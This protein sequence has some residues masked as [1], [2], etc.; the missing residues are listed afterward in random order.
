MSERTTIA[1]TES[2]WNP[3]RASA[4]PERMR[5]AYGQPTEEFED[6]KLGWSCVRVSPGCRNCYAAT[7]NRRLGTGLD[8][9]VSDNARVKHYL[10]ATL[11]APL[12]WRKP[13]R[14]FVCSMTDLFGEWVTDDQLDEIFAPERGVR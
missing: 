7:L 3:L 12:H 2:T 14:V 1:W 8:Y 10:D 4:P 5:D 6:P 13:R 9:T 11:S